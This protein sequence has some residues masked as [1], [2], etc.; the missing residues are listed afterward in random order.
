MVEV[1][2]RTFAAG[3]AVAA[4]V[5][6]VTARAASPSPD[7]KAM[8]LAKPK[9]SSALLDPDVAA[10]LK[11]GL[12]SDPM[13]I[14]TLAEAQAANPDLV[15]KEQLIDGAPGDPQVSIIVVSQKDPKPG[16]PALLEIHG[17]GYIMGSAVLSVSAVAKYVRELGCLGVSVDY[18]LA[19]GTPFPGALHDNYAALGWLHKNARTL[20]LDPTRIAVTGGSAGGGHAVMLALHA[21][22]QGEYPIMMQLL[23][24]PMLDDRTGTTLDPG[25][26]NGEFLWTRDLNKRGWTSLLGV[27]AGSEVIPRNSSPGRVADLRG[28]PPTYISVG[29]LDL[30][31][32]EGLD[33]ASRLMRAG[34]PTELHVWD[35]LPHGG[36]LFAMNGAITKSDSTLA[37]NALKRAFE[38]GPRP[39]VE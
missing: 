7:G 35:G 6:G 1:T 34:V 20:G 28:L 27:P 23:Q 25:P 30:F 39:R 29:S 36:Q 12:P 3:V 21:R 38:R 17:G 37:L 33:F 9:S 18:R 11:K 5:T 13:K 15:I 24:A 8:G 26:Y 14:P 4:T 22:D 10:G 31:A 19:P 2:R 32:Q 16:R